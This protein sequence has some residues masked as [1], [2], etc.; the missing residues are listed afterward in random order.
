MKICVLQPDYSTSA[1]DYQHYDPPRDLSGLMPEA[2]IEHVL[3]NKLTTYKQLKALKRQGYDVFVNLCEGY[4]EWEVPSIDVIYTLELLNLPFTGPSSVLYDPPKE[5]MKYVAFCEGIRTPAYKMV[6]C[7]EDAEKAAADLVFPLFVKPAKAGDS[8]GIDSRSLVA[9]K[10]ALR[11]KVASLF[12]EYDELLVEEYI[13]GREFTVMLAANAGPQHPCTVFK[14]VEYVFPEGNSFK[15][16]ALKTSE[17]H[18]GA[19]IP[20]TDE[21]LDQRLRTAAVKIFKAFNGVGY[22]R[23]DFRLNHG[24]ELFFLEINFTCSVFYGDGY[25]GSADHILKHDGFGQAAFLRHIIAEGLHR[26]KLKQK[27][28]TVK[29]NAIAGYGIYA[30]DEIPEGGVVF[31]GEEKAQRFVT[32]RHVEQHWTTEEKEVFRRYAYPVSEEVFLLWDNNPAEWAPQNHSCN[33]NTTYDGLNVIAL[34]HIAK[35]EELTL[36]YSSFL[37]ENMEPFECDCGSTNC[38]GHIAGKRLNSVTEREKQQELK[39]G[40]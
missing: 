39:P 29:G 22:A 16:Y 3:L 14:P 34:R 21:T 32:R 28:Y 11:E 2:T 20:V 38:R 23:L 4:L 33:P 12:P 26:H 1:I 35:D 7:M 30:T 27:K 19:N 5:L 15:T 8:L 40:T 37:D 9:D 13:D 24:G 6:T 18:P 25:E 36:D 10:E 17:L 31:K